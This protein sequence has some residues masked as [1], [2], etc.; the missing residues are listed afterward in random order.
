[1]LTLYVIT[2]VIGGILV[3]YSVIAGSEHGQDADHDTD[4]D[5]GNDHDHHGGDGHEVWIPFFSLRF[6]NY[7]LTFFGVT[8]LLLTQ[9]SD[10]GPLFTAW[11]AGGTGFVAGLGVAYLI[12]LAKKT[13]A[14]SGAEI[15]DLM[16]AEG[17]V[18]VAIR[19]GQPGKIRCNLKGE[20]LDLVA[21][22]DDGTNLEVGN[23]ALVVGIDGERVRVI[24]I[25]DNFE[26]ALMTKTK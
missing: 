10:I 5:H 13:E 24:Q 21:L 2:A 6:W 15:A 18:L 4:H 16:G 9:F 23:K 19:E 17:K 1:M 8:G 14:S 7:G 25:S 12:H 26:E 11:A 20:L 3:L 22:S